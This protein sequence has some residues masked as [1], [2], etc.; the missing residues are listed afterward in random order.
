MCLSIIRLKLVHFSW[1]NS[2]QIAINNAEGRRQRA[3]Q[4]GRYIAQGTGIA[5]NLHKC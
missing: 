2:K 1:K 4:P 5:A 3:S